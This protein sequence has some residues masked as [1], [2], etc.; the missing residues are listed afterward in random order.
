[1]AKRSFGSDLSL[2]LKGLRILGFQA[3][4]STVNGSKT[5]TE[6]QLSKNISETMERFSVVGENIKAFVTREKNSGLSNDLDFDYESTPTELNVGEFLKESSNPI[7]TTSS[8]S[9]SYMVNNILGKENSENIL[10]D[11][12]SVA[13]STYMSAAQKIS[14]IADDGRSEIKGKLRDIPSLIKNPSTTIGEITEDQMEAISKKLE[15]LQGSEYTQDFKVFQE[16]DQKENI[17]SPKED[18]V[19]FKTVQAAPAEEVVEETRSVEDYQDLKSLDTIPKPKLIGNKP[20]AKDKAKSTLSSDA[21]ARKVPQSRISRLVTFGGLAAGLSMGTLAELTRRTLGVTNPNAGEALLDSSP[22]LTEANAKRI[23]DTLCKVRGEIFSLSSGAALKLGQM[24]SI[25]DN[26]MINPQLQKVFERV[27]QSADFM[28][29]WQLERTL[30]KDFGANWKSRLFSFDDRPFAAA[31]IGQVHQAM[32]HD[33]RSVAMKIQYPGVAEGIESDINNLISTLSVAN[34]LPEGLYLDA[35]IDVAKK[36]LS[37]E[38]DYIREKECTKRFRKLLQSHS[39]YYVPEVIEELCTERVFTAELID[40]IAVDKCVSFDQETRNRISSLVLNL[41][42][43]EIFKFGFMQTDPNWSNFFYNQDTN[44][45]A[46][47]D[48]GACREFSKE[49]VDKYIHLIHGAATQDREKVREYSTHLGFLTGYEAK[50]MVDAHVNAVMILGE[51]FQHDRPFHFGNQDTTKRIQ[52]LIP[53]L[54]SHRMC[55][56]PEESY[57]LHRK[58]SGVFLLCAKLN[59]VINCKPLFYDIWDQY[60]VGEPWSDARQY[61]IPV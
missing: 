10:N 25:Q 34:I 49:F 53:I 60:K 22:F 4:Q 61:Q 27:R 48:F 42:L 52:Q 20:L 37:W 6:V 28:P 43:M 3:V 55:P 8:S 11:L 51:A 41:C 44:Q 30:V 33:G 13:S 29:S 23:V 58:M 56:P 9:Q 46:L 1:M 40:G 5:F 32:L 16:L 14:E 47:L 17:V 57:S 7:K 36:E 35:L 54:L 12:D 19:S 38:C 24:L 2:V 39:E 21:Q 15:E 59:A 18:S 50:V 31:S 26:S 45:I